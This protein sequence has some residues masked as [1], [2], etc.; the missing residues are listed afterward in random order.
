MARSRR[1]PPLLMAVMAWLAP[2]AAPAQDAPAIP[3]FTVEVVVFAHKGTAGLGEE[4]WPEAPG[5]PDLTAAV[6]LTPDGMP[7]VDT[8]AGK[9]SPLLPA[10][11]GGRQLTGIVRA[12]RRSST[13]EPLV[14][15]AWR[16]AGRDERHAT[17]ILVRVGPPNEA[18]LL[19]GTLRV[20]LSRYL[21]LR[22]DLVYARDIPP[23]RPDE[24]GPVDTPAAADGGAAAP[25]PANAVFRLS[26][27][28]RMRSGE[29]HYVDHPVFGLIAEIRRYKFPEPEPPVPVT[30]R[31][32]EPSAT[33]PSP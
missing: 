13:Y 28:R 14:H 3:W 22:A 4:I 7:L 32:D 1:F 17:S 6:P 30:G 23:G 20:H 11:A 18:P 16:Q 29:I 12:L 2:G 25:R 27:S 19:E 5:R 10:T 24:T 26:Q 33:A 31:S 9:M 21:H 15:M 8:A